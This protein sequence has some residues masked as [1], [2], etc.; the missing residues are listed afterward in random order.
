MSTKILKIAAVS[1]LSVFLASGCAGPDLQ[2]THRSSEPS[3]QGKKGGWTY[4]VNTDTL[5]GIDNQM[6]TVSS[7]AG[8]VP[9][10]IVLAAY[11]GGQQAAVHLGDALQGFRHS[12]T[13]MAVRVD[14][15]PVQHFIVKTSDENP[16]VGVVGDVRGFIDSMK[17]GRLMVIEMEDVVTKGGGKQAKFD[18]AGLA[19]W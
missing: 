1:V 8:T 15:R 7:Q 19:G 2:P 10:A 17:G 12:S 11:P 6:A 14:N 16:R 3:L 4:Y 9:A 18:I 5:R 13:T